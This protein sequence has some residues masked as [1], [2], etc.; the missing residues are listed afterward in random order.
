MRII[1]VVPGRP[2]PAP[3]MTGKEIAMAT[4]GVGRNAARIQRYHAWRDAA[5]MATLATHMPTLGGPVRM[6]VD[7]YVSGRRG[8]GSN[9]LKAAEDAL[10]GIA[11]D[12]DRQIVDARVR[13]HKVAPQDERVV[14]DVSQA[15]DS[16]EV[17]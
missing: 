8:D 17:V 1:I 6:F 3:R 4:R 7:V 2:V 15:A 14:I 11:Y 12:D 10:N 16:A 5:Q 13:L 9:Y